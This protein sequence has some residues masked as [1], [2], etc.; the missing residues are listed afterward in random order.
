MDWILQ[1]RL[2]GI[3]HWANETNVSILMVWGVCVIF[4][5]CTFS[6]VHWDVLPVIHVG[7]TTCCRSL[8]P[9]RAHSEVKEVE[10]AAYVFRNN[11]E[12]DGRDML[13]RQTFMELSGEKGKGEILWRFGSVLTSTCCGLSQL[14]LHFPL[15]LG[16]HPYP[17]WESAGSRQLLGIRS[18]KWL[19]AQ[20][21]MCGN[22]TWMRRRRGKELGRITLNSWERGTELSVPCP[23]Q[24]RRKDKKS[25]KLSSHVRKSLHVLL[26]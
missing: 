1:L 10:E 3:C 18:K 5:L 21:Q 6:A 22:R 2:V 16:S 4:H 23:W 24:K 20:S 19:H 25:L 14:V 7:N 13:K 26:G 12:V 17:L 9:E 15:P 11:R 8:H